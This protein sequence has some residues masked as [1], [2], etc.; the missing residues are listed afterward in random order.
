ML[1]PRI[2]YATL[3]VAIHLFGLVTLSSLLL[4]LISLVKFFVTDFDLHGGFV[5]G[6]LI[7]V[8]L[9]QLFL[10]IY[11]IFGLWCLYYIVRSLLSPLLSPVR[12]NRGQ[13]YLHR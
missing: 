11:T 4:I 9:I 8:V 3:R 6:K 12:P 5:V 1:A 2:A 7:G 13:M 10:G